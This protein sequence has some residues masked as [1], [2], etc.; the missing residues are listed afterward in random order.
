MLKKYTFV[1]AMI[2]WLDNAQ[3]EDLIQRFH[4]DQYHNRRVAGIVT[5][6]GKE[7]AS[8]VTSFKHF[9]MHVLASS[10]EKRMGMLCFM[11]IG[12]AALESFAVVMSRTA[13]NDWPHALNVRTYRYNLRLSHDASVTATTVSKLLQPLQEYWWYFPKTSIEIESR[14]SLAK[15]IQDTI[16][17]YHWSSVTHFISVMKDRYQAI[18][19]AWEERDLVNSIYNLVGMQR[20]ILTTDM[21]RQFIRIPIDDETTRYAMI[22]SSFTIILQLTRAALTIDFCADPYFEDDIDASLHRSMAEIK[23]AL[24]CIN[25]ASR[26]WSKTLTCLA[27]MYNSVYLHVLDKPTESKEALDKLEYCGVDPGWCTSTLKQ[28]TD[29]T[30]RIQ[31]TDNMLMGL[32]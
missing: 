30:Y 10:K 5:A 22:S 24:Q 19:A 7:K 20:F 31:I 4:L 21:T 1:L 3:S 29:C 15:K 27:H 2:P 14:P 28:V 12:E 26:G 13:E 8:K 18:I 6:F 9:H 23:A 16:T 11:L 17:S 32:E 25:M